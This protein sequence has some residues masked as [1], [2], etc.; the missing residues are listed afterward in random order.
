[1]IRLIH[2]QTQLGAL[3]ID[4]IDDGLPNKTAYRVGS[5]ADP[6]AYAR[7]GYA[8]KPKQPCYV[9]HT[10]AGNSALP[11]YVDLEETSRVTLSAG[12]GKIAGMLRAGL[13]SEVISFSEA[14]VAA[15]VVTGVTL[16]SP[17]TGDVT[18]AGTAFT[19]VSPQVTSVHLSGAGVGDVT[20]TGAE[21]I[22]V[23]PGSVSGT[24]I[25]IDSTL[26][27]GLATG[28]TV[29]VN[30]DAQNSNAFVIA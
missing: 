1:M 17:A 12:K 21:I 5:V 4:D 16:D 23:S 30:A 29:V 7:D 8:N 3:L 28:D 18:I 14:D 22:A 20:L 24:E 27:P 19:S 2:A 25:V 26:V 10:H 15:P 11:G 6:N 13:I 9:P